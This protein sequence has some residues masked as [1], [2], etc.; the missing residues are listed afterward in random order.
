MS[1]VR[2][3]TMD[4]APDEYLGVGDAVEYLA[5]LGFPVADKT[6]RRWDDAGKLA[7]IRTPGGQRRFRRS[8]LTALACPP[9]PSTGEADRG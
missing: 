7:S 1:M 6:L 8:D 3:L 9:A 5:S 4:I 2:C